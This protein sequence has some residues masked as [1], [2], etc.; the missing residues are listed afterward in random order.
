MPARI[1]T[2]PMSRKSQVRTRLPVLAAENLISVVV[3]PANVLAHLA[4]RHRQRRLP[5]PT[6]PNVTAEETTTIVPAP[7]ESALAAAA[8][9]N[10][11]GSLVGVWIV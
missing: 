1:V 2:S 5:I 3:H 10:F 11:F 9:N 8:P 6:R 7:L 4:R